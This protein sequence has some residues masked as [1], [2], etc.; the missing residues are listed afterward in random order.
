MGKPSDQSFSAPSLWRIDDCLL[1]PWGGQLDPARCVKC[2]APSDGEVVVDAYPYHHPMFYLASAIV[3]IIARYGTFAEYAKKGVRVGVFSCSTH[4]RRRRLRMLA[5]GL[6][7]VVGLLLFVLNTLI[8]HLFEAEVLAGF[9]CVVSVLSIP[10]VARV[11]RVERIKKGYI[12][13]SGADPMYLSKI[14]TIPME[15]RHFDSSG[16]VWLK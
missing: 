4:R 15:L 8:W 10:K 6:L 13:L 5:L 2:N 12:W 14:P 7:G 1:M 9:M 16:G 3:P 11:L